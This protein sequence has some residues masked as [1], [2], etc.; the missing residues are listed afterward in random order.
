[1]SGWQ[2]TVDLVYCTATQL[3]S[4]YHLV[5]ENKNWT[6]AQLHCESLYGGN[7]VTIQS[8]KEQ[9]ALKAYLEKTDQGNCTVLSSMQLL[10]LKQ[11]WLQFLFVVWMRVIV[12]QKSEKNGSTSNQA[13]FYA[14]SFCAHSVDSALK[15]VLYSCIKLSDMNLQWNGHLE[16]TDLSLNCFHRE[17][18]T[19]Y[20]EPHTWS[21]VLVMVVMTRPFIAILNCQ[22]A[23]E[24]MIKCKKGHTE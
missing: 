4:R 11:Y 14:A 6:D 1:M 13:D 9:F 5:I 19:F 2:C 24:T 8:R 20:I 17:L 21:G 23:V 12:Q 15:C 3:Q 10:G 22:N 18:K 16:R 7:L